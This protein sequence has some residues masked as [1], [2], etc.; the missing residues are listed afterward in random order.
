MKRTF[1]VLTAHLSRTHNLTGAVLSAEGR[2]AAAKRWMTEVT[3]P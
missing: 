3:G 2:I 1:P